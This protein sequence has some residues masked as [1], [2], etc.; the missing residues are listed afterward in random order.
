MADDEQERERLLSK[1]RT[2]AQ[3]QGFI[4]DVIDLAERAEQQVCQTERVLQRLRAVP[5]WWRFYRF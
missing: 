5:W 2:L 4:E 3:Q 1:I